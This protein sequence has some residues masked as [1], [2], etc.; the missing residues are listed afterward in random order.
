[1]IVSAYVRVPDLQSAWPQ[2]NE[3]PIINVCIGRDYRS[4]TVVDRM[5]VL[6]P[7]N[8]T[9]PL[10]VPFEH[11]YGLYDDGRPEATDASA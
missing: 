3:P 2:I 7:H 10:R 1:M 4:I 5:L 9:F 8:G 11:V 6:E